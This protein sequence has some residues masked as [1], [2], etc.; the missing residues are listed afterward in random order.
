MSVP[1]APSPEVVQ[2]ASRK[3]FGRLEHT[4]LPRKEVNV[5]EKHRG[6]FIAASL[7]AIACLTT[8]GI[9]LWAFVHWTLASYPLLF[10]VLG[11]GAL[12]K[13][14][15][16][17]KKLGGRRLCLFERGLL[18]D[19]GD[20]Q[21]FAVPWTHAV[22]YQETVTEV[23]NYK[24]TKTP[25]RSAHTSTVMAPGGAKVKISDSFADFRTW[26]PLIADAIAR[27][28]AQKV[29]EAVQDGRKTTYGPFELDA[30]GI[31]TK[32]KGTLPWQA[33]ETIDVREGVVVVRQ[34]GQR[35]AWDHAEVR[36]VPNLML[37]LTVASNLYGR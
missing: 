22:H 15:N 8:G 4:F 14:P 29:W 18:V 33:V 31:T 21:L 24:G 26:A 34:H 10:A 36:T 23:I 37:F 27:A 13:S 35:T 32:R 28:Q 5:Q 16:F 11:S 25:F 9:L 12:F 19:L 17:R 1:S 7:A 3:N 20:G 6:L 30:T 2:L